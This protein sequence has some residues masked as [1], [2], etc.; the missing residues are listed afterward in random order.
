MEELPGR[1]AEPEEGPILGGHE[2][3]LVLRETQPRHRCG[4]CAA[5]GAVQQRR[6]YQDQRGQPQKM[7]GQS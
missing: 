6:A 2:E 5:D 3:A 7:H 1:I 4:L